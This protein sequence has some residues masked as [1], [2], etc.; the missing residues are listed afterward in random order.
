MLALGLAA[1]LAGPARADFKV[2][3][4][5]ADNIRPSPFFPMP[6][7]GGAGVALFAGAGPSYDTGAIRVIN[8]GATNIT[9]NDMTSD[10]YGDGTVFHIWGGFLGAGFVLNPGKSA[11]F[12]QTFSYNFD[13]SDDQGANPFA[14]P[15]VKVTIDGTL[16]DLADT[17]QVLNTEGT[18]HLAAAGLNESHQW[19]E[20]GTFGGQAGTPE[21]STF[22]I[23]GVSG[24]FLLG[25]SWIKRRKAASMA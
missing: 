20:I 23:A 5:Y 7:D 24:L 19:R 17:A 25:R 8:T 18:D 1:A 3:V 9:I 6:W 11:I 21:P 10:G 12:A 16:H 15:H 14:I 22:V 13:S 4:G 2:Q